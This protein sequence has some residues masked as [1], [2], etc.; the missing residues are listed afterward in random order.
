M[1]RTPATPRILVTN[2]DGILAPGLRVLAENLAPLGTVHVVA[3]S[4]ER[5]GSAQALSVRKRVFW[6]QVAEHEWAV[7]GT[8]TDAVILAICHLFPEPPDIVISGINR[9]G[10]MGENIHYSGTVGAAREAAIHHI[11]SLAVSVAHRGRDFDYDVAA[12]CAR[13]FAAILLREGLPPG[14]MLNV[15]VPNPWKGG[16]RATRQSPK[17]TRNVLD[18]GQDDDGRDF[19]VLHEQQFI[20]DVSPDTDY[21]AIFDGAI[22]VTP[23]ILDHTHADLLEH[24]ARWLAPLESALI[25]R[26]ISK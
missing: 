20:T 15:N 25:S 22:S 5:S 6:E 1:A 19:F 12:R 10:N 13:E 3:P 26:E 9:G 2:D 17:I 21:A 11:P 23:L 4:A 8:P 24:V 18:M 16:I 7:E 14:I